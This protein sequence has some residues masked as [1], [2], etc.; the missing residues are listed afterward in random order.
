MT[1]WFIDRVNDIG[2]AQNQPWLEV[3]KS[4]FYTITDDEPPIVPSFVHDDDQD[5]AFNDDECSYLPQFEG[6]TH[7][8]TTLEPT[9]DYDQ[10]SDDERN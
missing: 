2:L 4:F 6:A 3:G 9:S 1:S 5:S 10:R 8:D 7:W